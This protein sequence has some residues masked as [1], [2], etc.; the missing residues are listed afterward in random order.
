MLSAKPVIESIL[1]SSFHVFVQLFVFF[2]VYSYI[3][4]NFIRFSLLLGNKCSLTLIVKCAWQSEKR[5]VKAAYQ[6]FTVCL[7]LAIYFLPMPLLSYH[8]SGICLSG[9]QEASEIYITTHMDWFLSMI[10][11]MS[12]PILRAMERW[13]HYPVYRVRINK[14]LLPKP[15]RTYGVCL[16]SAGN[17][18][19]ESLLCRGSVSSKIEKSLTADE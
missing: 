10:S 1:H 2:T 11:G 4:K 18:E 17:V 7:V 16:L 13:Q 3:D 8:E 19:K 14:H 5:V 9:Q 6:I 12:F 15:V